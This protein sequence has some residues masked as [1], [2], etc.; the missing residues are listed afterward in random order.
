[1]TLTKSIGLQNGKV[2]LIVTS[3]LGIIVQQSEIC[4]FDRTQ[5]E[6]IIGALNQAKEQLPTEESVRH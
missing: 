1:M 2:Y 3:P 6:L 4:D 5:I